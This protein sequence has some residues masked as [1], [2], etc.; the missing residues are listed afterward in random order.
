MPLGL[1][2][3]ADQPENTAFAAFPAGSWR[4]DALAADRL[5]VPRRS[6]LEG[7]GVLGTGARQIPQSHRTSACGLCASAPCWPWRLVASPRPSAGAEVGF[8]SSGPSQRPPLTRG[9]CSASVPG[10][11]GLCPRTHPRVKPWLRRQN[12][13]VDRPPRGALYHG[14]S[15]TGV[16]W[17]RAPC[18]LSAATVALP[19]DWPGRDSQVPHTQP[20]MPGP[21]ARGSSKPWGAL[22]WDPGSW[23]RSSR[24]AH[25]FCPDHHPRM[26]P[27]SPTVS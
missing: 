24:R 14:P 17:R 6:P 25:S 11:H 1:A 23:P 18:R 19:G 26:C 7:L 20:P 9:P 2:P 10:R 13:H 3:A 27:A 5:C 15:L 4:R 12:R 22:S 8:V 16:G 21:L